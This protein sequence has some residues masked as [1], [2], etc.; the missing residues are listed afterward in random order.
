ML[1]T[2]L[3]SHIGD[4]ATGMTWSWH[5]VDVESCWRQCCQGNLA[6]ARCRCRVM[7]AT[8]LPSHASDSTVEVTWPQRDVATES[9]CD[10]TAE[11]TV[12]GH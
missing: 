1:G 11:A 9:W 12:G 8:V 3:P 5:D 2:V 10:V 4:G 6:A 7:L